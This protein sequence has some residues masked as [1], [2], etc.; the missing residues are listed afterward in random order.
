MYNIDFKLLPSRY[1]IFLSITKFIIIAPDYPKTTCISGIS[2]HYNKTEFS[3]KYK[4]PILWN[5]INLSIR[6]LNNINQS[7]D[8]YYTPCSKNMIIHS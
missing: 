1:K 6:S 2:K 5:S 4:G 7:N 8:I 3:I